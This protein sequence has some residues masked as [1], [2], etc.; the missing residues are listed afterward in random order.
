MSK[1][2][3]PQVGQQ[4]PEIELL[5]GNGETWKLSDQQGKTVVLL[6]Y[7]GDETPVCTKQLCS[8]RDNWQRYLETGAEVVGINTDSIEKHRAF[9]AN[10]QLPMRLLSD[11][12]GSVV[13]AYDMK[14][15]LGTRRGVVIIGQDGIIR[16]R[17]V[18]VPIFRPGDD[19]VLAAIQEV[20]ASVS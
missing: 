2:V 15:L 4:A 9:A 10:H 13:R 8:V 5:D 17:K 18:V 14:N 11:N 16:F 20:Q 1:S 12:S 6:F 7:P 3:G 19:E